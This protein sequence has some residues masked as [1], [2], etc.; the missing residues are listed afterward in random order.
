MKTENGLGMKQVITAVLVGLWSVIWS[1]AA[2][3]Q[4][5]S[6]LA[7][8]Q[9]KESAIE[10]DGKDLVLNLTISQPVP[11]RVRLLAEP[12][13]LILDT[14]NVDWQGLGSLDRPTDVAVGLRAGVVRPGWSRLV[15][16]LSG[17]YAVTRAGMKTDDSGGAASIEMRL[18]PVDAQAFGA[19]AGVAEP[20]EWALP[21]PAPVLPPPA[22]KNGRLR[23]VLDPGHGGIDPG[24]ENGDHTEAAIVL[25]FARELKDLLVRAGNFDVILTREDDVF[26]PIE[27]RI[28]LARAVGADAFISLHADAL[29]EGEAVGA[30]IYT[31]ADDATDEA[32]LALAERH[33][34]DDLL[35][36][37]DLTQQD[38]LV[39]TVLIDMA[40]AETKPR[41]DRLVR[42]LEKQIKAEGLK[43]HRN[44]VQS[45]GFSVLK[46]PDIPSLLL[47]LGFLSSSRDLSRLTDPKWR[48]QMANAVLKALRSWA[49]EEAALAPLRRP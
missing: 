35:S 38:D 4:E 34:R 7:R 24:A 41:I 23:I 5:L 32:A 1:Y 45:G 13:R 12:P 49:D 47:E 8:F 9:A 16:E 42:A 22:G 29:A 19:L 28:S 11:W 40:R 10:M 3:G 43:M 37:V 48:A 25:T 20:A 2:S 15:A 27:A 33:D 6:A 31:L 26:V 36:G 17:F 14:R 46:S 44:P 30:T 18:S 39:A 21:A